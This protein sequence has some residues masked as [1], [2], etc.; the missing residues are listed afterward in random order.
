MS[1]LPALAPAA[2][3]LGSMKL[4]CKLL[5]LT[6]RM[7]WTDPPEQLGPGW[8]GWPKG[9]SDVLAKQTD[10][11]MASSHILTLCIMLSA[12]LNAHQ[13]PSLK[14]TTVCTA[15]MQRSAFSFRLLLQPP[16]A[17]CEPPMGRQLHSTRAAGVFFATT[18]NLQA[19]GTCK[20]D[21]EPHAA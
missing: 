20:L 6:R 4:R 12:L 17:R 13:L 3:C 10:S 5:I 16:T 21:G 1:A 8:F 7:D 19:F 2:L 14:K 11:C 9:A 15:C 18:S